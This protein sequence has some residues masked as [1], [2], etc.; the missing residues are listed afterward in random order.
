VKFEIPYPPTKKGKAAWNKRFGLNAYYAGKHWSK[1][2]Q[3]A[4]ELHTLAILC[5]KK[6]HIRRQIVK[7]PVEIR[8]YWNDGLDCDNHA[9]MGKAFVDAMTN[10]ILPDDNREWVRKV[11]HEFWDGDCIRV[12][13]V[14]F[15]G[16]S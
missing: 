7:G 11:S 4:E 16:A 15:G 10:Y 6:A 13:I 5:M 8:F 12:E 9:A 14:P 1:R 2:K 3:D